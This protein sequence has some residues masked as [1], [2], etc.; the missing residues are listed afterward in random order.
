MSYITMKQLL[1]SGVHFGHQTRRWNPK[2]KPYI[3]G[4]RNGIYIIDLQQTVRMFKTAYEFVVNTVA[5]G[6]SIL[7]VGTKKQAR[8][9]IYE[10]ANRCEMFYVHNRWL[11]GMLT[12]FQTIKKGIERLK[13]LTGLF[14]D[15]SVNRFP[16][17]E[18]LRV[19]GDIRATY[20]KLSR[21][22]AALEGRFERKLRQ[23][24]LELLNIQEG[25]TVLEVG[26]GTG[27]A[28]V[29]IAKSVGETGKAYGIDV[30]PEML[31]LA[32][33]RLK[34]EG[35]AERVELREGDARETPYEDNKFDAVYMAAT[36]ELFD[37]PDIPVVLSEVKR[38]LNPAGRLGITSMPKEGHENSVVFRCYEWVHRT[39]P[40]YASCRPIYVEDSVR[41]AGFEIKRTEEMAIVGVFPMKIVIA[42]PL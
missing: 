10:E 21:F 20:A 25:E 39:F 29:E 33:K 5:S 15:G 8:D 9:S 42:K 1:E 13:Y 36:L 24:G 23:R 14:A 40:R 6:E 12:N 30:T 35:L 3:F 7:F 26:S 4:A 16:K 18:I 28:L 11:G 31:A 19:K 22:Y 38:V 37:T 41:D 17:K 32:W 27:Y 2:M 34:K